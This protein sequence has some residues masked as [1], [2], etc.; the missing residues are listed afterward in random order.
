VITFW[1]MLLHLVSYKGGMH[2]RD[3]IGNC[4]IMMIAQE[5]IVAKLEGRVLVG[6]TA[7]HVLPLGLGCCSVKQAELQTKSR[8]C[9]MSPYV[10]IGEVNNA[11]F[12][13][14]FVILDR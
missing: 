13:L 12:P 3:S 11:I 8:Q 1:S 10:S 9:R 14:W 5:T 4:G 2:V 7:C 6:P